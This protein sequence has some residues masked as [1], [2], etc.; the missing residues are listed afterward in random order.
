M[1]TSTKLLLYLLDTRHFICLIS[2]SIGFSLFNSFDQEGL[3]AERLLKK[4]SKSI[5]GILDHKW[6]TGKSDRYGY[7]FSF[8]LPNQGEF[9]GTSYHY[10]DKFNLRD[11]VRIEY[12][13]PNP[14][15]ARIIKM[16]TEEQSKWKWYSSLFLMFTGAVVLLRSLWKR[17]G[18][19][20]IPEFDLSSCF[21]K[22]IL[23]AWCPE[24]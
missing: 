13:P 19:V 9:K 6:Y 23:A 3:R 5:W 21:I 16:K 20:K 4:E 7:D 8:V 1:K 12:Y 2:F 18:L 22:V 24:S 10:F 15:Y 11:S 14:N 17:S